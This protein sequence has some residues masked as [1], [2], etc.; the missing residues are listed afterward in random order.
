MLPTTAGRAIRD[1]LTPR[2]GKL[3]KSRTKM[4]FNIEDPLW[5][6]W[7]REELIREIIPVVF[8]GSKAIIVAQRRNLSHLGLVCYDRS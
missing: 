3:E 6:S 7:G 2:G 5:S 1:L 8:K 4:T